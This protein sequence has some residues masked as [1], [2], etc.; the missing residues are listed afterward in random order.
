MF[1][2][3]VCTIGLGGSKNFSTVTGVRF[4]LGMFE[5]GISKRTLH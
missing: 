4:L 2:W 1:S 3:G 5:A